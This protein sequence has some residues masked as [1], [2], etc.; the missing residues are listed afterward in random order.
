MSKYKLSVGALFKNESHCIKEWIEHYRHHNVSHFYLIDDSSTDNSVEILDSYIK[1]GIVTLFNGNNWPYYLGRQRDMYNQFIFPLIHETKWL[2][3]CDL[4]EF[5]WTNQSLHLTYMLDQC[6]NLAQI[7]VEQTLFGSNGHIEQPKSLVASFTKRAQRPTLGNRKYFINTS[8]KFTSLNIHHATFE[9]I[10]Y[11]KNKFI[12]LGSPYFILNHYNCQ[13][14][15]FWK[16]VKCTRGDGDNFRVRC[17]N[18]FKELDI[19]EF[20]DTELYEQNKDIYLLL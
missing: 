4:D 1:M 15:D 16:N 3:I 11:E 5:M 8:F 18:D 20:V 17:E 13:S 10:E 6:E 7:Q 19:N 2:L 12:C 14:L 9:D